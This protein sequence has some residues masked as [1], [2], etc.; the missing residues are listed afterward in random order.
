MTRDMNELN[1]ALDRFAEAGDFDRDWAAASARAGRSSPLKATGWAAPLLAT[2]AVLGWVA[3]SALPEPLPAEHAASAAPAPVE[4]EEGVLVLGMGQVALHPSAGLESVAVVRP[5]VASIQETDLD[6]ALVRGLEPGRTDVLWRYEDGTTEV[7]TVRVG[8]EA[9]SPD[10]SATVGLQMG[11]FVRFSTVEV[12]KALAIARPDLVRVQSTGAPGGYVLQ[13]VEPGITD[14]TITYADRIDV[15][16]LQ[17]VFP[18]KPVLGWKGGSR[19]ST[20]RLDQEVVIPLALEMG[21]AH[22]LDLPGPLK[23]LAIARPDVVEVQRSGTEAFLLAKEPGLTD[24]L[25][26]T[27]DGRMLHHRLTVEWGPE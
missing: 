4:A 27:V 1:D 23:S 26:T 12:P 8:W 14:L 5:E 11:E 2:A 19:P 7:Q 25:S 18:G 16:T 20:V 21:E 24:V 6:M 22:R 17:V 3:W 13:G 9:A 10:A 15:V